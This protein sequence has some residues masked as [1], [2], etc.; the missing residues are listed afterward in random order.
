MLLT[1]EEEENK[2]GMTDE[3]QEKMWVPI[4]SIVLRLIS[5]FI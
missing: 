2:K 3:F 4:R 1:N 5:I